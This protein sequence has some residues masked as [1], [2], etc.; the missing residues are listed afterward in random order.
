MQADGSTDIVSI[1]V[2][3]ILVRLVRGVLNAGWE[4]AWFYYPH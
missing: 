2:S 3:L 4:N 1:S